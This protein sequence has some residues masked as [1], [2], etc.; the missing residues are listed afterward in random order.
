MHL[1]IYALNVHK[2]YVTLIVRHIGRGKPPVALAAS[3]VCPLCTQ[4]RRCLRLLD[5]VPTYIYCQF[6]KL[7]LLSIDQ[8]RM[9]NEPQ[10]IDTQNCSFQLFPVLQVVVL[11][12]DV[13]VAGFLFHQRETSDSYFSWVDTLSFLFRLKKLLPSG[14]PGTV[15]KGNHQFKQMN[16][17]HRRIVRSLTFIFHFL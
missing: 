12:Q 6:R 13:V 15:L 11:L 16:G 10:K 9:D 7:L 4:S 8:I 2:R 5:P 3:S 1:Y 17:Q 14:P